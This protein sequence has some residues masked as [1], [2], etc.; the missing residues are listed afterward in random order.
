MALTYYLTIDG[1]FGNS[2]NEDYKGSFNVL[3]YSF[4][5]SAIIDATSGGGAGVS[6]PTFSPLM[7][8][9]DLNSGLTALLKDAATGKHIASIELKGVS[10]DGQTVYDLKLG[11]VV[12]TTY[13]DTNSGHD[14]L[15]FSYQQVSLTTIPQDP[16]G[17]LGTPV[18]FSWNL[19]T[20]SQD[21]V[22]PAPVPAGSLSGGGGAQ[23][24]YLTI[25]GILGDST[26]VGYQGAFNVVDYSFDVSAIIDATSGSGAGTS[27]P[28]FSPLT[29]DLDLNSGLTALLKDVATGKHIASIELKG[30]SFYG[31]T[32]YD[33]V[34][35]VRR[36]E[37]DRGGNVA[38][39]GGGRVGAHHR[40]GSHLRVSDCR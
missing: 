30:V 18:T 4:D 12:L 27:K 37:V 29:V 23:S 20:N 25:D 8:D 32:V 2:T 15:T 40:S 10:F 7:V 35:P 36:C 26:R 1:I 17:G 13:H 39:V 33:P 3:D 11:D 21:A 24:Y 19:A 22:I 16:T 28:T 14:M 5:V 9:L 38:R 34:Q 6:K 31:Q